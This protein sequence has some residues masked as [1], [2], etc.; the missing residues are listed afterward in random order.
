MYAI[1]VYLL[2]RLWV[3][4]FRVFRTFICQQRFLI[5]NIVVIPNGHTQ[6]KHREQLSINLYEIS[7]YFCINLPGIYKISLRLLIIKFSITKYRQLFSHICVLSIVYICLDTEKHTSDSFLYTKHVGKHTHTK[8]NI[9]LN[10]FQLG[11]KVIVIVVLLQLC[12]KD[13]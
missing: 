1:V 3:S 11:G 6:H 8:E 9:F 7:F 5:G 13:Q 12:A 4:Q 2:D 10:P